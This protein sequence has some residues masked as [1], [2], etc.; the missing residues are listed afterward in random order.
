LHEYATSFDLGVD[1]DID[2]RECVGTKRYARVLHIELLNL[3]R[4]A[5]RVVGRLPVCLHTG[6]KF[7]VAAKVDALIRELSVDKQL[8]YLDRVFA[9]FQHGRVYRARAE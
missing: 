9:V 4:V 6:V 3:R 2:E 8:R 1:E 5:E 7:K